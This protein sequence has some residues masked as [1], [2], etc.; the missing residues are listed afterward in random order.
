M[1]VERFVS[2]ADALPDEVA[3]LRADVLAVFALHPQLSRAL[4]AAAERTTEV[5]RFV[6]AVSG[7]LGGAELEK[8]AVLDEAALSRRVRRVHALVATHL[9][10]QL[11]VGSDERLLA[12]APGL[13]V[14]RIEEVVVPG[15]FIVASEGQSLLVKAHPLVAVF[16]TDGGMVGTISEVV[17]RDGELWVKGLARCRLQATISEAPVPRVRVEV[18]FDEPVAKALTD[19]LVERS[20][21]E[22]TRRGAAS[23]ARDRVRSLEGG[24]LADHLIIALE[25]SEERRRQA[26]ALTNATERVKQ[27]LAWLNESKGLAGRLRGWL[28]SS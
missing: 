27:V 4:N 2:V 7:T 26:W 8:Q 16:P 18:L 10:A 15:V 24:A 22:L 5:E 1:Q 23:E 3:S 11:P 9:S 17:S 21:G 25:L 28:S 14:L 19:E 12:A 13:P 20:M 6:D